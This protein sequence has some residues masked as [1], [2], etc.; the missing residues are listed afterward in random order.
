[1]DPATPKTSAWVG[2][3]QAGL[4]IAGLVP[5]I[6]EFAD[7]ANAGI[8]LAQ[9]DYQLAGLSAI[10]IIPVFGDAIGKSSKVVVKATRYMDEAAEAT[11]QV[12][13]KIELPVLVLAALREELQSTLH[14]L[15]P[16]LG[17]LHCAQ[18]QTKRPRNTNGST[19]R[20]KM[21]AVCTN[22]LAVRNR[23]KR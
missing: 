18:L 22:P 21:T 13:K 7:L 8:Y 12:A 23:S 19:V 2:W 9:G 3:L 5:V 17:I 20:I 10:S 11:Q 1:M 14:L 6:G 16:Y 15:H 4:D